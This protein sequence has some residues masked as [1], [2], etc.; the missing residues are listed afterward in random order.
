MLVAPI[1]VFGPSVSSS[2]G[3]RS[4]ISDSVVSHSTWY[5]LAI[6]FMTFSFTYP[7]GVLTESLSISMRFTQQLGRRSV[8]AAIKSFSYFLNL[9]RIANISGRISEHLG[10]AKIKLN[11]PSF[12]S[13]GHSLCL[14]IIESL[15]T[16]SSQKSSINSFVAR[17]FCS[18]IT[19]ST[20]FK[21][22]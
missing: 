13:A 2:G 20:G 10:V 18:L 15:A 11:I 12:K 9:S 6:S 8:A 16:T 5:S 1:K 7:E 19:C 4:S 3:L 21:E 22:H 17:T 14:A